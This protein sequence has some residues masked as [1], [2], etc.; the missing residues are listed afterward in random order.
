MGV[1][2]DYRCPDCGAIDHPW[3]PSPPPAERECTVCGGA[4]R[5]VFSAVGVVGRARPP[6]QGPP[7][8]T[9]GSL[10]RTNQDIPGL[11]MFSPTAQRALVARVRGDNRSLDAELSYQERM[12]KEAPGTLTVTDHGCSAHEHHDTAQHTTSTAGGDHTSTPP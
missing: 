1:L 3:V 2:A 11:C 8:S 5:R 10:C 4:A 7:A 12:Q 6:A 9:S